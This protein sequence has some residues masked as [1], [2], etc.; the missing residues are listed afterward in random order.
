MLT[1]IYARKMTLRP[2]FEDKAGEKLRRLDKFFDEQA[3]A[4]LLL[5]PAPQSKVRAELT[6]RAR[7]MTFRAEQVSTDAMEA[8]ERL[9][10][11]IIRQ[12]RKN[13]TRLEKRLRQGAYDAVEPFDEEE[14]QVVKSKTFPVK[15]MDIDE[16]ILQMNSIGHQFYMFRNMETGEINVVYARKDGNYGLLEPSAEE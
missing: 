10:D 16:A 1:N 8:V 7:G 14:F 5:T 4:E 11:V 3:S 15:P 2:S 13:K 12:I 9:V 6:V